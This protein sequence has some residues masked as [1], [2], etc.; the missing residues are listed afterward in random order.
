LK[1]AYKITNSDLVIYFL[2]DGENLNL[3]NF[4]YEDQKHAHRQTP[5][6]KVGECLCGLAAKD[7]K[8]VYSKDIYNDPRCRWDECKKANLRSFAAIPLQAEGNIIGILG[9]ASAKINDYS[10]RSV[11]LETMANYIAAGINNA[12]LHEQQK[13]YAIELEKR[14]IERERAEDALK[15]AFAEIES[16]KNRL[17]A[18][19]VYLQD[20]IKLEH[21]FN[22]IITNNSNFKKILSKVE[23]VAAT[24][25][26]VLIL[27]ETGTGKELIAR[28]VHNISPRRNRPLV[29]LNCAALPP[30]LIESELFG[31][32]KGAFTG[33]VSQKIGRFE[34]ADGG[35]IFLDEIGDLPLD[36]QTKL[37]RVLQEG[38]FE[39]VGGRKTIKVDVRVLAATN[40]NLRDNVKDGTF[41][42]DLYYRLNVFPIVCPPLNERKDDIPLL[43]NHFVKKS[44]KK[45]GKN[46]TFIP[47]NV[48]DAFLNYDWP[49]NVR[50]LEN[51]I[52]RAVITSSPDRLELTGELIKQDIHIGSTSIAPLEEY[53]RDYIIKVLEKVNWRVSGEKGA[54]KLLGLNPK[55]LES[56]MR[57][58]NIRRNN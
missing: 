20:E 11:F 42:E 16:L 41:R 29:K 2:K 44:C 52:E 40:R 55:T 51:I 43:V 5:T 46:I 49:G 8:A 50:E 3:K 26:T 4:Y 22:E 23:Q 57:K 32:E 34:L 45:I 56:R 15:Q 28:A 53:E 21:N 58:L 36:L 10:T 17:Q 27:G 18:E 38:E 24:D 39:R 33:A 47:K 35:T 37:L 12:I 19:N 9:M 25:A 1:E 14:V 54:A 31:H 7:V 48:M 30:S 6:H 13:I